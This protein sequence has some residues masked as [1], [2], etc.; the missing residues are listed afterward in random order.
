VKKPAIDLSK[1]KTYPLKSRQSKVLVKDFAREL[2]PD[3]NFAKFI[4]GLPDILSGSNFKDLVQAVHKAKK[5]NKPVIWMFGAH[6]IKCG[7]SPLIIQ[8]ARK[9]LVSAIALNGAGIIHDFEI[10]YAGKT[11]EDVAQNIQNGSFGMAEETGRII[12]LAIVDAAAAGMGLG[13]GMGKKINDL[14]CPYRKYS[15]L[16]Q[17]ANLKIPVT[18][19]AAIGTDIIYQHPWCDGAA[20]GETSYRDFLTLASVIA[21]IGDGGVVINLGSAVILPEVFLKAVTICRNLGY[22]IDNFT[23]ANFDMI[24]QY[25]PQANIV[26]R[27]VGRK[28]QGYNFIGQHE[29]MV[30]LLAQALLSSQ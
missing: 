4:D 6:V 19:H 28:G 3:R 11:S 24:Y 10:A 5:K 15:I 1:I 13:E 7:L 26:Q 25:R 8:L 27:P 30:P 9:G 17:A 22:K 2:S 29:I 21:A 16:A 23:T 20:I 12:N 18:V 14:E